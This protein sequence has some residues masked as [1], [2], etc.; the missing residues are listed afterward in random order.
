MKSLKVKHHYKPSKDIQRQRELYEHYLTIAV[1]YLHEDYTVGSL[2]GLSNFFFS[3]F[4]KYS[5]LSH[6]LQDKSYG[7][8]AMAALDA[9][10]EIFRLQVKARFDESA[11]SAEDLNLPLPEYLP[12]NLPRQQKAV[13]VNSALNKLKWH[14]WMYILCYAISIRDHKSVA[15][16]LQ[17]T[18]QE[19]W[20]ANTNNGKNS[21]MNE[22]PMFA[23]RFLK[24]MLEK[25]GNYQRLYEQ[26]IHV[27][28]KN[29]DPSWS[30]LIEPFYFLAI[31][32]EHGFA[33]A[34]AKAT[35]AHKVIAKDSFMHYFKGEQYLICPFILGASVMAYDQYGW[36]PAENND[37][38]YSWW[39]YNKP[40]VPV[41]LSIKY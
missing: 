16:I 19:I 24:G 39:I 5:V 2:S 3:S 6:F 13:V 41:D 33:Q 32:D 23:M 27:Y 14:D 11:I 25:K 8:K 38:L 26:L 9:Y 1:D 7:V 15:Y 10:N 29:R 34:I 21:S 28:S 12:Q 20:V 35:K 37:Y 36:L 31:K 40:Q 4:D 30:S 18:E 17:Y 22:Y